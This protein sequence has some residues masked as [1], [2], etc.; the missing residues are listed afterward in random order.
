[1][2]YL[3]ILV[4]GMADEKI[5][6]LGNKTPL[7]V[8]K[9]P[10][11]NAIAKKSEIG[12][13]NTIPEG[14]SPGS[15]AANLSVMGFDPKRYHTGRSPL[16]A[17]SMGIELSDTDVAFRCNLVTLTEDEPYEEKTIIDH[18]SG[19][20]TS[21]EAAILIEAINDKFANDKIK[22][23]PGVSYRHAMILKDGS[24]DFELTPPHDILERKIKQYLPKG[25]YAGLIEYI[26]E[27]SYKLLK[28]HPVNIERKRKGLNSANSAW[29][30]GQGNKP[31]LS[32]FKEKYGV[33]GA[34]ISAVDLIKGIGLCAGLQSIDV[35]GATGT[36][37]TNFTGKGLAAIDAFKNGAD[38]VYI[39]IEAPD[40]CSH[41]GDLKGKIESIEMIDEKIVKPLYDYLTSLNEPFKL[42]VVPDHPTPVAI[43]THTAGKVPF[44]LYDSQKD[45]FNDEYAFDEDSA[46]KG[47]Y[48]AEGYLLT[49]HF[50]E[51]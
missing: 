28:D 46:E 33:N 29:I 26:M 31:R 5:E 40:E 21:Q 16:E 39:H 47:S 22:F 42:L 49:N 43:R 34:V 13:V 17:V 24:L 6:S 37:H 3:I 7:Q 19:D 50:F 25:P 12:M 9:I 8:S 51:K 44:V 45:I 38:F 27:E 30:W 2:K 11:I 4:D 32:P 48:F 35:E 41:Q 20:I 36:I 14:M 1:M 15:D 18:S 10:T 23:Y